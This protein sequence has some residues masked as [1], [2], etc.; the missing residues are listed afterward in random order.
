MTIDRHN[1]REWKCERQSEGG[2]AFVQDTSHPPILPPSG[3]HPSREIA[4]ELG[5]FG[6][7]H[8]SWERSPCP[9]SPAPP[10]LPSPQCA[11]FSL[12]FSFV[13][14]RLMFG[15]PVQGMLPRLV[16]FIIVFFWFLSL[17]FF[18]L[19]FLFL[20]SSL[21]SSLSLS[22]SFLFILLLSFLL[23]LYPFSWFRD[24]YSKDVLV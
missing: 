18:S 9:I 6:I 23:S 24:L 12:L 15:F 7:P 21:S 19:P 8:S 16:F 1:Q 14:L 17:F 11:H 2:T 10:P 22:S 4:S 3:L 20:I 13:C 5:H